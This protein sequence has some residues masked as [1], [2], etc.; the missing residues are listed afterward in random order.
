MSVV[1]VWEEE[2]KHTGTLT[3]SNVQPSGG[4]ELS[5]PHASIPPLAGSYVILAVSDP[6]VTPA[7]APSR[8]NHYSLILSMCFEHTL[9]GICMLNSQE[10]SFSTLSIRNNVV[11]FSTW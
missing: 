8:V 7:Q 9:K 4:Y 10:C 5:P 6:L 2:W 11:Q 3:T 1:S